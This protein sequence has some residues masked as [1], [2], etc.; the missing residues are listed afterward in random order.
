[1]ADAADET[2]LDVPAMPRA[3][4]DSLM[5]NNPLGAPRNPVDVTAN[6]LNDFSVVDHALVEMARSDVTDMTVAFFTSWIGLPALA[7]KVRAAVRAARDAAPVD[8]MPFAIVGQADEAIVR[9]YED[10]GVMIFEDPSRAVRALAA[11]AF[12][13]DRGERME[14]DVLPEIAPGDLPEGP[15]GEWRATREMVAIGIAAPDGAVVASPDEAAE[16]ADDLSY[17]VVLKIV[18]PHIAHKSDIGGVAVGLGDAASVRRAAGAML[19]AVAAKAPDAAIEGLLV[20]RMV[21]ADGGVELLIGGRVDPVMGPIVVA[22]LGGIFVEA[23]GDVATELAPIGAVRARAMLERLRGAALLKGIRGRPPVDMDAA[24]DAIA[25]LSV[26]V[27]HH[28]DRLDSVEINPLL[29]RPDGAFALDAL[30][31]RRA[32]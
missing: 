10:E 6:A 23:M 7:P 8:A 12:F 20:T 29:V 19:E 21:D 13:A 4:Q 16:A 17:P 26:F 9:G 18:S 30:I 3:V 22:G 11:L 27:D 1:M 24:A 2:G 32:S 14:D 31:T 15:I 5:A 28:R 25:R